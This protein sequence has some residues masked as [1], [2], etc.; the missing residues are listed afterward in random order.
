MKKSPLL[1]APLSN[2]VA[3]LGH[4][5]EYTVCDAGLP[6]PSGVQRIDLALK[7]G[8]P[9]FIDTV[10]T[11]LTESQVESV[12]VAKELPEKNPELHQ[13]LLALLEQ[14]SQS[15]AQPITVE[16][17][18]HEAFKTQTQQSKA[19]VRTGECS[20]YANIILRAGVTF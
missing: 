6:I 2:L 1:N 14:E 7:A 16:Y 4:T 10:Q 3:S 9:S 8:I 17:I 12:I 20:S 5:D 11:L 13:A 19:V 15:H 18:S